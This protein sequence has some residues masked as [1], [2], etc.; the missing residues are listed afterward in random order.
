MWDYLDHAISA[1]DREQVQ[2][3]LL[4]CRACRGELGLAEGLRKLLASEEEDAEIPS[5]VKARFERF[6]KAL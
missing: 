1:D 6:V 4:L 2:A 3:H 5:H